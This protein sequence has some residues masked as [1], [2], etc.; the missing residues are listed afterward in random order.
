MH[1]LQNTMAFRIKRV[2]IPEG[3]VSDT[4]NKVERAELQEER[5]K[6]SPRAKN[7]KFKLIEEYSRI[8][9]LKGWMDLKRIHDHL[10][11]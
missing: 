2:N 9:K 1:L 10:I 3:K 7:G 11:T 5:S 6:E 8:L 4:A